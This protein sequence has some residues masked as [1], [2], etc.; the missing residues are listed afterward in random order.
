MLLRETRRLCTVTTRTGLQYRDLEVPP[1][2]APLP[3]RGETVSMHYEGRLE[4][5][6]LFD[7]SL[8]RGRPFSFRLGE[9]AVIKGWEEGVASLRVGGKRLLIVPPY[10][11]YGPRGVP[12][13]IPPNA[14]LHFEVQLLAI[15]SGS[16]WDRA[17]SLLKALK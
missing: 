6:T 9:R 12:P 17:I 16:L 13:T 11:G 8:D 5:G 2:D 4:D 15:R 3:A 7:S 10:L 14:T 1:D